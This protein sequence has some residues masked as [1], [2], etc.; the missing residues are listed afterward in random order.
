MG[1]VKWG[2]GISQNA[3]D[4]VDTSKQFSPYDGPVPPAGVYR[5]IVKVLKE[6]TSSNNNP[7]LQIGLELVPRSDIPEQRRYKGYFMMDFI[8]VMDSVAWRLRPF[9][10]AIGVTSR[11][12]VNGTVNDEDKNITKIGKKVVKGTVIAVS[13]R[14]GQDQR[15]NARMEVAQYIPVVDSD[16]QDDTADDA[17]GSDDE[18]PF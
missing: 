6:T 10:D 2:G 16:D 4:E 11:E 7:Q 9:L 18:P 1:K 15:G 3:L 13:I 12:F 17:S 5:F 14:N 8:P